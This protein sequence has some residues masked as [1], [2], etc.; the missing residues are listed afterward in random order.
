MSNRYAQVIVLAEDERSANL[1]RRYVQRALDIGLRQ[2]RQEISPS[3]RGDAKQW[4]IKRYPIE[5]KAM[6]SVHRRTGLVVHLDADVDSVAQRF[7]ELV[8]ALR[9][10]GQEQRQP[11]ERVSHVIPR[12]HT[13]TWLCVL[14]GSNVDEDQNC[15]RLRLPPNPDQAVRPAAQALYELTR[16]NAPAPTLPSL[17][18]AI[19]ELRRLET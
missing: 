19:P 8:Q 13:E 4:V 10:D 17:A 15:K 9:N 18:T 7:N 14:T 3:S 11:H 1:L 12:R 16:P 5:I 2:I 6:R